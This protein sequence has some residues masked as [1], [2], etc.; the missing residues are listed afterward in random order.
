MPYAFKLTARHNMGRIPKGWV[1]Q[2][3]STRIPPHENDIKQALMGAG[4]FDDAKTG[5]AVSPANWK[6]EKLG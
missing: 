2:V 1:L 3:A 6:V 5:T 4:F